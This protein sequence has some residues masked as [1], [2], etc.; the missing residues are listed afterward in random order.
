MF[1]TAQRSRHLTKYWTSKNAQV[2]VRSIWKIAFYSWLSCSIPVSALF[3]MELNRGNTFGEK[4][5]GQWW[6]PWRKSSVVYLKTYSTQRFYFLFLLKFL[7]KYI[8]DFRAKM[9]S[10]WWSLYREIM[11]YICRLALSVGVILLPYLG[12]NTGN[13]HRAGHWV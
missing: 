10:K 12:N 6:W 9:T 4:M 7:W 5:H 3:H 1:W 11:F 8:I 2:I 13:S